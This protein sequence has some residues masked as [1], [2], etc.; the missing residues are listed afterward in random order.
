MIR[1]VGKIAALALVA[2]AALVVP[3]QSAYATGVCDPANA[4]FV[5]H[6]QDSQGDG[7]YYAD[8]DIWNPETNPQQTLWYCSHSSWTVRD[9]MTMPSDHG[10]QAYPNVHRDYHDWGTGFEPKL[11]SFKSITSAWAA[12]G[13]GAGV[14]DVAY[15]IWLNGVADNNS[16]ELMVWTENHNQTP[17]GRV[18]NRDVTLS[19]RTWDLWAESGNGYLAF[20]PT[21]GQT[22]GSGT[23]K[24][25]QMTTWLVNHNRLPSGSTL[26]QVDFGVEWVST[27]GN[28]LT[29]QF[30]NF[31]VRTTK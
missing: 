15:D 10:V 8:G 11:S 30:T 27:G 26:G 13:P 29:T 12:N 18:V 17:A 9:N 2:S 14:Y 23:L 22:Y 20:V 4:K 16:T 19:G 25:K 31:N 21:N 7:A 28:D 6:G 3:T 5:L 1:S 24:I